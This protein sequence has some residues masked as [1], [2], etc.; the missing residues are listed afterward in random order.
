[1]LPENTLE[2]GRAG[3]CI[4]ELSEYGAM[5]KKEIGEE[6]VFDFS[7]GSPSVSAPDCVNESIADDFR[8]LISFATIK[9]HGISLPDLP[10]FPGAI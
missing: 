3:S 10:H 5:R 2:W 9:I 6:N 1:M 7:I 4:R 8:L